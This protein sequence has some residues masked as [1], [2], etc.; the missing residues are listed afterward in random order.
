MKKMSKIVALMACGAIATHLSAQM[1][2]PP[3]PDSPS[4]PQATSALTTASVSKWDEEVS[5]CLNLFAAGDINGMN[6]IITKIPNDF[7]SKDV[8][9]LFLMG[10]CY[11]LG[12][13]VQI[14]DEKAYALLGASAAAGS[15]RARALKAVMVSNGLV[16][17][18]D[19]GMSDGELAAVKPQLL[20]RANKGSVF[21][22]W[23]LACVEC[24][25][26]NED[27]AE[28]WFRKASSSGFAPAKESLLVDKLYSG[29]KQETDKALAELQALASRGCT[30]SD[31]HVM[32]ALIANGRK[33]EAAA[34]AK[35]AFPALLKAATERKSASA[36]YLVGVCAIGG[37]GCVQDEKN[38]VGW[39]AYAANKGNR[40]A[41]LVLS[42]C[43]RRGVGVA[44]NL[45]EAEAWQKKAQKA[46]AAE[47]TTESGSVQL[48][49]VPAVPPQVQRQEPQVQESRAQL[50]VQYSRAGQTQ[51]WMQLATE[52]ERDGTSDETYVLATT[53]GS[54]AQFDRGLAMAQ[55]AYARWQAEEKLPVKPVARFPDAST[56]LKLIE[57]MKCA[58]AQS[59][60]TAEQGRQGAV[61]GWGNGGNGCCRVCGGCGLCNVCNGTGASGMHQSMTKVRARVF[62]RTGYLKPRSFGEAAVGT[63]CKTCRGTGRCKW[64][65]QS[66]VK[67]F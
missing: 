59:Q 3:P 46:M 11:Y 39:L 57:M 1:A 25:M 26:G 12:W 23:L 42:E 30:G 16:K 10:S 61:A 14:D 5:K 4:E 29:Q 44:Q 65:S 34:L 55:L 8:N 32:F 21:E 54:V 67:Q 41:Q 19:P 7:R 38:G 45:Q 66:H 37:Y 18:V 49:A 6:A 22:Q 47:R 58:V 17:D 40:W 51:Q 53:F 9:T 27:E 63:R 20:E 15:L 36:A 60:Q 62:L 56:H 48:S 33:E 13:G 31:E 50:I 52:I 28:K 43:Y 24:G 64:C 35:R 2:V